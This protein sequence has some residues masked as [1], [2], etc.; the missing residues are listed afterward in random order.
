[1]VWAQANYFLPPKFPGAV[2]KLA[3]MRDHSQQAVRIPCSGGP[4]LN[5]TSMS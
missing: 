4:E 2:Y 1:M 3:E 5:A